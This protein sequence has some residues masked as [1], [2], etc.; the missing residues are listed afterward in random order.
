MSRE[1]R[2]AL[3]NS[4]RMNATLNG[5]CIEFIPIISG[6]HYKTL[7][8]LVAVDNFEITP[9]PS[10]YSGIN[11][12]RVAVYPTSD[13]DVYSQ[14]VYSAVS[15]T[16]IKSIS[17]NPAPGENTD[18][19]ELNSNHQFLTD[20][21]ERRFFITQNPIMYCINGDRLNRYSNYGFSASIPSPSIPQIII[22]NVQSGSFNIAPATLTR[23]AVVTL[24]FTLENG[25]THNI[26]QEVQIRNV[27]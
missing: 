3:P 24:R 26:S 18:I 6:S 9:M 21:P 14:S 27:P 19:L 13:S 16:T 5:S 11:G 4:L 2:N 23:N 15:K 22:N 8:V 10:S 25:A 7:P 12:E 17:P 1:L 20:S